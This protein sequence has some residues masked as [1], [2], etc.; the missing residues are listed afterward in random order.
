MGVE[1]DHHDELGSS[2]M[3]N[4]GHFWSVLFLA[5]IGSPKPI[6]LEVSSLASHFW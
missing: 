6:D 1:V 3:I 5:F 2:L 4:Y